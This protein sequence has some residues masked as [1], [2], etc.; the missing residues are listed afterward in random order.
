MDRRTPADPNSSS[1]WITSLPD[2]TLVFKDRERKGTLPLSSND[3]RSGNCNF[4]AATNPPSGTARCCPTGT[5]IRLLF[6]TH[7]F[8]AGHP[9]KRESY[10][11]NV[12]GNPRYY[13][14]FKNKIRKDLQKNK[15]HVCPGRER[16]PSTVSRRGECHPR[17]LIATGE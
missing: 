4:R 2:S 17:I 12:N 5:M 6:Q 7:A 11:L 1:M 16:A 10:V 14:T 13:G 9:D 8:D 3:L 15:P